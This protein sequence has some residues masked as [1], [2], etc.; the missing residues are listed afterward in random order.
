MTVPVMALEMGMTYRI[1][2]IS[3]S[4]KLSPRFR[5]GDNFLALSIVYINAARGIGQNPDHE[6]YRLP[7]TSLPHLQI[8]VHWHMNRC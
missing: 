5:R 8:Q 1:P 7:P 2:A 3:P 4:K 6:G